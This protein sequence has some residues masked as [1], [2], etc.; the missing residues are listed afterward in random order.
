MDL[1]V[2]PGTPADLL[3]ALGGLAVGG[4]GGALL[5]ATVDRPAGVRRRRERRRPAGGRHRR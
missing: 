4:A 3:A 1:R 2:T 5:M